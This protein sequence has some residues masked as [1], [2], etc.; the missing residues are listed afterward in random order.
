MVAP[1]M[2]VSTLIHIHNPEFSENAANK[3][4]T[5]ICQKMP[6]FE[7]TRYYGINTIY[8][9]VTTRF[10]VIITRHYFD[11]TIYYVVITRYYF[12]NTRY[13]LVNTRYYVVITIY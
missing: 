10:C 1:R 3:K 12:V 13:Y 5:V 6:N 8:Y 9:F 2:V 11:N 4:Q 7:D